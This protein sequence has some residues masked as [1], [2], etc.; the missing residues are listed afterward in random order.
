M[1]ISQMSGFNTLMYYSSTL[2]AIVGFSNP[3]A[4]GLVV[5]GTNFIMTWVNMMTVDPFGRRR[6]LITTVWGMSAGLLAV[7]I[8]FSF[9]PVDTKTLVLETTTITPPAIVVRKTFWQ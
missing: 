2:F 1:V 8:A 3:V 7:A 4:V 6:V 9:I 5:A